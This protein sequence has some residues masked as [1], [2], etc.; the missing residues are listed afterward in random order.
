MSSKGRVYYYN[1]RT[2]KSQWTKPTRGTIK[3][4]VSVMTDLDPL[5]QFFQKFGTPGT[6]VEIWGSP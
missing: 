3:R 6:Y 5:V 4:Y 2:E 1:Q